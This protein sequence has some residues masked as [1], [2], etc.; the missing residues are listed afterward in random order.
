MI[1]C[2]FAINIHTMGFPGSSAGKESAYNVGD[3]GSIPGPGTSLEKD[4]LPTPAFLGFP[5]D[6][7]G[8]SACN[9]GD[10][11]LISGVGRSP[12]GE[13]GNPLQDSFLETPHGQRSLVGCSPWVTESDTAGHTHTVLYI[14][15][16][17]MRT[18]HLV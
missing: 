5:G 16:I 1:K 4:R 9:A 15:Q 11:G 18:C 14:E 12:G 17:L 6:S 2:G 13:H 10:L 8:K 7:D 3:P